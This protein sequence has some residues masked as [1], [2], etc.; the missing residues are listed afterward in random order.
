[1]HIIE[2][3]SLTCSVVGTYKVNYLLWKLKSMS[4]LYS[5]QDVVGNYLSRL[6][7]ANLIM[8]VKACVLVFN[9]EARHHYLPNIVVEGAN[10]CKQSITTN[11]M[12]QGLRY[13]SYLYTMLEG[14]W[15]LDRKLL[16]YLRIS[17]RVFH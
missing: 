13:I 16:K 10:P 14:A 7:V 3:P 4:N 2:I 1:M 5:I 15:C 9:K 6:L 17:I 12:N 8:W 11:L